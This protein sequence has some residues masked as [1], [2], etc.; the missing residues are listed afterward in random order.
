MRRPVPWLLILALA[1]GVGAGL[2]FGLNR[3]QPTPPLQAATRYAEV[4]P[5]L[6]ASYEAEPPPMPPELA[7]KQ[8]YTLNQTAFVPPQCYTKTLDE[9]GQA[10]NPCYTCHVESRAPNYVNDADV[11]LEYSF[12]PRARNNP[13]KNLF[14][15]WTSEIARIS[16]DAI[17]GYV[18]ASNYFDAKGRIILADK[19]AR[20]PRAWDHRDDG[21][22]TGFVP[23]AYFRFDEEGFDQRPDGSKTGWR[24]FAYYPLP[25]TFWPT[26][27]SIG[28]VLIRLP[29]AFREREDGGFDARIYKVNLAVVEALVTRRSVSVEAVDEASLGVDLDHDGR[30]G[31]TDRVVLTASKQKDA[32]ASLSYVGRARQEAA[33]GKVHVGAGLFPEGTEF[34]HTVRYLD[35]TPEG[36]RMAARLKELRYTKKVE[37]WSDA[38]LDKRA[39]VEAIAKVD[40]PTE[41]RN[42]GGNIEIGVNNNQGWTY[43]AFIEDAQ[44]ALRPQS[45]EETAYCTGCHGGVGVVDDGI[46]SFSR[47]LGPK[48]FQK[49]WYHWSQHGLEGVPDRPVESGGTE[50]VRY[51]EQNGAGDEFRQNSEVLARFFEAGKLRADMKAR[52]ERDVSQVLLP[53][54][55]RALALDKAYQALVKRQ[56]FRLGREIV[57]DG[58]KNV[59]RTVDEGQRTGIQAPLAPWWSPA[60]SVALASTQE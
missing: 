55:E 17:L 52:L 49:G 5:R 56:S 48:A 33:Q 1:L 51:L 59:Q 4:A 24:A 9:Q 13:W 23:D 44:G 35:P 54:P 3:A 25:G 11:Q 29:A 58:A 36:I 47:R 50:Y 19:L 8:I 2:G 39:Q 18:R 28:D 31:L 32:S 12:I 42:F 22:W 60:A 27:G 34:L 20:P 15:D 6:S 43:Q 53:S 40:S 10:H 38:R 30:L 7:L 37:W 14:V 16:D 41:L 57:L 45:F 46:F 26:N 21:R